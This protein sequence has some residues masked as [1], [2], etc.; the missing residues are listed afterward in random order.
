VIQTIIGRVD[1]VEVVV[2]PD[3]FGL[4]GVI[5]KITAKVSAPAANTTMQGTPEGI[6]YYKRGNNAPVQLGR[7]FLSPSGQQ[8]EYV[9]SGS[10][11]QL[12]PGDVYWAEVYVVWKLE[13]II[14]E[15]ATSVPEVYVVSP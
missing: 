10:G 4:G 2:A 15:S 11:G 7:T 14:E 9:G 13:V 6:V 5:Y 3:P 1:N 12:D 8:D